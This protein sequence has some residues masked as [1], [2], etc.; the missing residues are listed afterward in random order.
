MCCVPQRV[1]ESLPSRDTK[2]IR[3]SEAFQTVI[4]SIDD[5]HVEI[6]RIWNRVQEYRR[7]ER[8]G[9]NDRRVG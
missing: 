9:R 4:A 7:I 6:V 2:G 8:N 1:H 5:C 3:R